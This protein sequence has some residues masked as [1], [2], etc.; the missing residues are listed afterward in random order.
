MNTLRTIKVSF[1]TVV[2]GGRVECKLTHSQKRCMVSGS[3]CPCFYC[4]SLILVPIMGQRPWRDWWPYFHTACNCCS[5]AKEGYLEPELVISGF[6]RVDFKYNTGLLGTFLQKFIYK[7]VL[8][9]F[10]LFYPVIWLFKLSRSSVGNILNGQKTALTT[11]NV[12]R[13]SKKENSLTVQSLG[14]IYP[15]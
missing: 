3:L 12:K 1:V 6:W 2:M 4:V 14:M 15:G 8:P 7:Q 13:W 11:S 5:G 9:T 10:F